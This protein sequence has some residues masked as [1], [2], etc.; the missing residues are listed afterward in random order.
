MLDSFSNLTRSHRCTELGLA[1]EGKQV[2][3][4]GWVHRRRDLGVVTFGS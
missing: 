4:M 2:T 3:V 1:D